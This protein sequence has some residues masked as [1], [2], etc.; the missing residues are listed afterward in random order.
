MR[1][2]RAPHQLRAAEEEYESHLFTAS[3]VPQSRASAVDDEDKG[4]AKVERT[5]SLAGPAHLQTPLG[6]LT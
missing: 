3:P 1:D 4:K 6:T 5:D 2:C